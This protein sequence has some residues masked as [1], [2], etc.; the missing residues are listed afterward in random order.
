[1]QQKAVVGVIVHGME[2]QEKRC[3]RKLEA[4]QLWEVE[5]GHIYIV[6][7]GKRLIRYQMLRKSNPRPPITEMIG[8]EALLNY[9]RQTEA[10]LVIG[11]ALRPTTAWARAAA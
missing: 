9:L 6:E 4:G 5:H 2:T 11:Q 1:M 3:V 10:Q 8:V 7:L